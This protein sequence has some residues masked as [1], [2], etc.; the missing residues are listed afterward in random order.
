MTNQV[1]ARRQ[2]SRWLALLGLL[3]LAAL[4]FWVWQRSPGARAQ[5]PSPLPQ[6]PRLQA[7]FNQNQAQ[8]ADYRDPYRQP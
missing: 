4:G 8:S 6:D 3:V 1:F 7:Y 5:R 2:Y